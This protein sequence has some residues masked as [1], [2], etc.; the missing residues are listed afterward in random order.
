[1]YPKEFAQSQGRVGQLES[2]AYGAKKFSN[3]GPKS[4]D[5]SHFDFRAWLRP[6]AKK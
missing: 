5:F 3:L 6:M 2:G 1:L 4:A